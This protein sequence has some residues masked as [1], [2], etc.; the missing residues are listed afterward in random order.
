MSKSA[1]SLTSSLAD[2]HAGW[3]PSSTLSTTDRA[4]MRDT[5]IP[6]SLR[7][8]LP[9]RLHPRGLAARIAERLVPALH[10]VAE[11]VLARLRNE[12]VPFGGVPGDAVEHRADHP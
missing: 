10:R 8:C 2:A 3:A 4:G 1:V 6:G 5:A 11:A 12:R 9:I 7:R